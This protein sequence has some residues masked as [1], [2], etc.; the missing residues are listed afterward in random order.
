MSWTHTSQ[1]WMYT[2][3]SGRRYINGRWHG[4]VSAGIIT[5]PA[6][7]GTQAYGTVGQ[8]P[9]TP[10]AW[11]P[12]VG[13]ALAAI[14]AGVAV[15]FVVSRS[16]KSHEELSRE[17]G[18]NPRDRSDPTRQITRF[19]NARI[20][21]FNYGRDWSYQLFLGSDIKIHDEGHGYHTRAAALAAGKFAARH[22]VGFKKPPRYSHIK[23]ARRH[24]RRRSR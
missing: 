5:Q 12:V 11:L 21:T 17:Y 14:A 20:H 10:P 23:L 3:A 9:A 15:A 2:D 8:A 7:G 6:A 1:G 24:S 19:G 22:T 13:I 16:P 18:M 4:P